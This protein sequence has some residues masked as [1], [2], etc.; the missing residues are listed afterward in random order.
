MSKV[1]QVLPAWEL[2]AATDRAQGSPQELNM[3]LF[4]YCWTI[5]Q[6]MTTQ[7]LAE[8]VDVHHITVGLHRHGMG[9]I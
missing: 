9:M 6:L 7:Q 8:A 5:T 1:A 3:V 4:R 2:R